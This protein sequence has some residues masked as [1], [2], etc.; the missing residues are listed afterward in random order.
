MLYNTIFTCRLCGTYCISIRA[1]ARAILFD[2][3]MSTPVC[4]LYQMN[5]VYIYVLWMLLF[6]VC[7]AI[8][9][10]FFFFCFSTVCCRC[11]QRITVVD[12]LCEIC[13]GIALCADRRAYYYYSPYV[14]CIIICKSVDIKYTPFVVALSGCFFF[15]LI[16]R[17]EKCNAHRCSIFLN[18]H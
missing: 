12:C 13:N 5:I 8:S 14:A 7:P 17:N 6:T 1:R 2:C 18:I 9:L 16:K 10:Y 11:C 15:L 3:C 4:N